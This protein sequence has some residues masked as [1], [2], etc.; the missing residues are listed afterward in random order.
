MKTVMNTEERNDIVLKHLPLIDK[1]MEAH[2][3]IVKAARTEKDDIYQQ[4]AER[5]IRAVDAHD[6]ANG[7][8]EGYLETQ[9]E[10]ELF[11]CAR[12]RRSHARTEAH[13]A[14]IGNRAASF[15]DARED[16]G[17]YEELAA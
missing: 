7:E 15:T 10:R 6:S 8:M 4:L 9:L 13:T 2:R 12:P 16:A 5:M 11:K 3:D 17:E 14:F 1:V